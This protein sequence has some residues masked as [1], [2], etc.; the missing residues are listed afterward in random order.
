MGRWRERRPAW[1]A[2][3]ANTWRRCCTN[4]HIYLLHSAK[5]GGISSR[6]FAHRCT[7]SSFRR[8]FISTHINTYAQWL[9]ALRRKSGEAVVI[10]SMRPFASWYTS[11]VLYVASKHCVAKPKCRVARHSCVIKPE[12]LRGI[13]KTREGELHSH[14]GLFFR[15]VEKLKREGLLRAKIFLVDQ[16]RLD[17]VYDVISRMRC[18]TVIARRRNDHVDKKRVFLEVN[19]TCAELSADLSRSCMDVLSLNSRPYDWVA[20]RFHSNRRL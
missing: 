4:K 19:G 10:V 15:A 3:C 8:Q 13:T 11:A 16:N 12:T 5:T 9:D 1:A 14:L 17:V 7:N 18:P 20:Y 2:C 6:T